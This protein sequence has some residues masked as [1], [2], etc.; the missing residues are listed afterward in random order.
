M[1]KSIVQKGIAGIGNRLQVLGHCVDMAAQT[2][3]RVYP[4]WRDI[5]WRLGF[6]D[7]FTLAG[8]GLPESE[9]SIWPKPWTHDTL[10]CECPKKLWKDKGRARY[11]A[12]A[13][14]GDTDVAVVCAYCAS[15]SDKL[16]QDL[17]VLPYIVESALAWLEE[18]DR[19]SGEYNCWHIRHTDKKTDKDALQDA[20]ARIKPGDVVITDNHDITAWGLCPSFTLPN[21]QRGM[22]HAKVDEATKHEINV[23]AI[24]DMVIAGL[25]DK[26]TGLC[27]KSS[28]SEFIKRGRKAGYWEE[29]R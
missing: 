14:P 2:G 18:N 28:Y 6:Y 29:L 22:H 5:S 19:K 25:A 27:R 3:R 16:F 12:S 9:E 20:K 15:Y 17:G 21:A 23:S 8:S 1:P 10:W 11:S 7:Y 13:I 24:R 26:F 4:D